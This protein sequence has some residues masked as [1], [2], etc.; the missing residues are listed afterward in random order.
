[1]QGWASRHS[2]EELHVPECNAVQRHAGVNTGDTCLMLAGC[3]AGMP[4]PPSHGGSLEAAVGVQLV[5]THA[6]CFATVWAAGPKSGKVGLS[7]LS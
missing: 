4:P 2:L 1:M 7:E 6:Q 5:A 3:H